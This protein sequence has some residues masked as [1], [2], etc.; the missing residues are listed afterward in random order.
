[1]VPYNLRLDP[2]LWLEGRIQLFFDFCYPSVKNQSC[3]NFQWVVFF[4]SRTPKHFLDTISAQ[5]T[6]GIIAFH[7]LDHWEKLN[8]E[9]LQIL[10]RE[11]SQYDIVIST[12]LDGDDA[13]SEYF[14]AS[15]QSEALKLETKYPCAINCSNGVI[16][17]TQSGI[18]YLKKMS[19]NAFISL[20]QKSSD[21]DMSIF[22]L[23]HQTISEEINTIEIEQPKMWLLVVHGGN[24][25]NKSSG[26][27]L[28]HNIGQHFNIS[29][30]NN[31][32]NPKS[33]KLLKVYLKYLGVRASN[34]KVKV[35][36]AFGK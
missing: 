5:D 4:D 17:D 33:G 25:V 3:K 19:S 22:K 28:S 8:A 15:I 23:E 6:E 14:I 7:Y 10:E 13:V 18:Y 27:P 24:L 12:R 11:K 26:L 1:M 20:V 16:L 2:D 35:N 29:R 36:R 21:L 30:K 34:L 31:S 32:V 9:V